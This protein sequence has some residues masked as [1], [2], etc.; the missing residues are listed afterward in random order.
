MI[1]SRHFKKGLKGS[2]LPETVISIA[3]I[4]ICVL[5][6]FLIYVNVVKNNDSLGYLEAKHKVEELTFQV[7]NEKDY[8]DS[9]YKFE[10]Y[11]IQKKVN[12]YDDYIQLIFTIKSAGKSH[13]IKK[14]IQKSES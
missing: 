11:T 6:A 9:N 10:G 13:T 3:I 8:L 14:I 2:S 12:E 4:S 7:I 5:V 1:L